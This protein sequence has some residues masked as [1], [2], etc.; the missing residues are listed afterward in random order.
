M[1]RSRV[2]T[3]AILTVAMSSI[4]IVRRKFTRT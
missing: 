4:A 3:L 1:V 2:L